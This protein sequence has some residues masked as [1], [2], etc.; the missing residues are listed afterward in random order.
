MRSL[1]L[2]I[3]LLLPAPALA[4]PWFDQAWT[5]QL[6]AAEYPDYWAWIQQ[7][8]ER[9]QGRY[10]QLLMQGRNMVLH[11]DRWPELVEAWEGHFHATDHY[12]GLVRTW[13]SGPEAQTDALRLQLISAAEDV[14]LATLELFDAKLY[15]NQAQA[16]QLKLKIADHELNFDVHAQETVERSVGPF[17][18]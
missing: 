6:V 4:V 12:R 18:D 10:E 14:H 7:V 1:L 15:F 9:N 11:R 3:A 2:I 5:E 13:N 17:D 16:Q 8:R